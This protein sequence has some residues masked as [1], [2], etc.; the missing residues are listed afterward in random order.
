MLDTR[1]A[2]P[3]GYILENNKYGYIHI[4][5]EIGRGSSCIVYDAYYMDSSDLIHRIRIKECYPYYMDIAREKSGKLEIP[6]SV[7]SAFEN[8]K[9]QFYEAY[10]KNV[11]IKNRKELA[12]STMDIA[13]IFDC[14]NTKYIITNVIEG[15]AYSAELDGDMYTMFSRIR[16][17]AKVVKK[18][19]D[20]G[21]LLLDLKPENIWILPETSDLLML[22]DF[23][24]I[25]NIEDLKTSSN[26]R[27]TFSE[28]YSAPE[29][30]KGNRC[31]ISK[32][33]DVFS[34]GAIVYEQI[35]GQKPSLQDR[36][37]ETKYDF[38]KIRYL[39]ERYQPI[40]FNELSEFLH[41]TLSSA[42]S[43]RY[44]S[45]NELLC[46]LD[47]LIKFS[48]ID[49]VCLIDNFNYNFGNFVGR[50]E[51]IKEIKTQFQNNQVIFLS[52]IGGIGKTEL[53]KRFALENRSEFNRIV[54]ARF[55]DSIT[56][57]VCSDDIKIH[58]LERE[59]E[60][61]EQEFF[62]RKVSVL[63]KNCTNKDL[64]ILDNMD[65]D[66]D[67]ELDWELEKLIECGC[68]LL[69]TTRNDF[70][71]FDYCQIEISKIKEVSE[72]LELF[73]SYN[74]CEYSENEWT[75][76][77]KIIE[78]VENH[79]M[80]IALI[81]KYLRDSM[82]M[83]SYLYAKMLN[84]EGVTN[85]SDA[86]VRH[87]KDRRG[88]VESVNVH[89]CT[90][91][92]LSGF[93]ESEKELMMSLSLLGPVRIRATVFL[94]Y[95]NTTT[96]KADLLNL[97]KRGWVEY[98]DVTQK[99][100]LHQIIM[101]LTYNY[102]NPTSEKC[103][104][105]V[106]SM[107][108]YTEQD[109]INWTER[110]TKKNF[111]RGI[112]ER[113]RGNDIGLAELLLSYCEN[114]YNEQMYVDRIE[115]IL[116]NI[117]ESSK[118]N[119][120]KV[121][122]CIL[123]IKIIKE[124]EDFLET[125][126]E[127]EEYYGGK[128][129]EILCLAENAC[130]Y[131]RKSLLKDK[132]LVNLYLK[133]VFLLDEIVAHIDMCT[134]IEDSDACDRA[135]MFSD[136]LLEETTNILL[137]LEMDSKEKE[138][139]Y[140]RI[141]EFYALDDFCN[142][143]RSERYGDLEKQA[144]YEGLIKESKTN[145]GCYS[146][147]DAEYLDTDFLIGTYDFA[148]KAFDDGNYCKAIDL[149][150]ACID[151][152]EMTDQFIY[153]RMAKSYLK[154]KRISDAIESYEN[155]LTLDK[156]EIDTPE[157][158]QRY[159]FTEC[160]ELIELL[161]SVDSIEKAHYYIKEMMVYAEENPKWMLVAKYLLYKYEKDFKE[162]CVLWSNCLEYFC[163]IDITEGVDSE[164]VEFILEYSNTLNT[165]KY[166][167]KYLL[168]II[169][170]NGMS[171]ECEEGNEKVLQYIIENCKSDSALVEEYLFALQKY[172]VLIHNSCKN[173]RHTVGKECCE[174][175]LDTYEKSGINNEYLKSLLYRTL[176]ECCTW[177]SDQE[178]IRIFAREKCNYY[179]L[180]KTDAVHNDLSEN[181][182]EW[183]RAIDGY[184]YSDNVQMRNLCYEELF[185]LMDERLAIDE[186]KWFDDYWSTYTSR[187]WCLINNS[188]SDEIMHHLDIIME[189]LYFHNKNNIIAADERNGYSR[190]FTELAD[191]LSRIEKEKESFNMY[192][193]GIISRVHGN[194][195]VRMLRNTVYDTSCLQNIILYEVIKILK[196]GITADIVDDILSIVDSIRKFRK[197]E[198]PENYTKEVE[199]FIDSY[200]NFDIEFKR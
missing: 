135:L 97:I 74:P 189:K 137:N 149:F 62:K 54:F 81:S 11:E 178:D 28:G 199:G 90:L 131:L 193:L 12:N 58:G 17:L 197:Y 86:K 63:K 9:E 53:A 19:H 59:D 48:K 70:R 145:R 45:M 175:A 25:M 110:N 93:T 164:L 50:K 107:K 99:I 172:A 76:I 123:K 36:L 185:K 98:D 10:R 109:N 26:I 92:D 27:L 200:K 61:S 51:E 29:L 139:I 120:L 186:E 32:A 84:V 177:L 165:K 144:Y 1:N 154:L 155:L 73:R 64:I 40:L 8:E 41:K 150:K 173:D 91:F 125:E 166:Q 140:R 78:L 116:S 118:S 184:N 14:N 159:S 80:S 148:E 142:M 191:I 94:G 156:M 181:I 195:D 198:I 111:L 77:V 55:T 3:A 46:A 121:R 130:S 23:D 66:W 132:E 182:E 104:H 2:L 87:K 114:L 20:L 49:E 174:L 60:E 162:K 88:R 4:K 127:D 187:V 194:I 176:E 119:L 124:F 37:I 147:S 75:Y 108:R 83:P 115:E 160:M 52:G 129:E 138:A 157:D 183:K 72:L 105:I 161:F 102:L 43:F 112:I 100:S 7:I 34:I 67:D 158:Y 163:Q 169:H 42:V 71:D 79:T 21:I 13:E 85:T 152:G 122:L 16:T 30:V 117:M 126:L 35:F 171:W 89:L 56:N 57:T 95:C 168:E 39:D 143:Y 196:A 134:F 106:S 65:V 190:K 136:R 15:M 179:L 82:E 103:P 170:R 188:F 101:D 151:T 6:D 96:N 5:N 47:N 153:L 128:M 192:L 31:K 33:T 22:F 141:K 133:I 24:S 68:K 180:A 167:M 69:I 146:D 44:Q 113:V 18:Y 38:T